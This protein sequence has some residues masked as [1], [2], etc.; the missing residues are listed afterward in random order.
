MIKDIYNFKSTAEISKDQDKREFGVDH[1]ELD[2]P[3]SAVKTPFTRIGSLVIVCNHF[4]SYIN[5]HS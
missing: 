5:T 2:I 1:G 3:S 4:T